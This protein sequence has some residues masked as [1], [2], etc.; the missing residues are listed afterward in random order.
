LPEGAILH[1]FRILLVE[2]H[3]M[4]GRL[5]SSIVEQLGHIPVLAGTA[6]EAL[7]FIS[8]DGVALVIMNLN[9]PDAS[10]LEAARR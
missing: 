10:G 2:D 6:D 1:G 3:E 8:R 4:V 7:T 9:L 5:L